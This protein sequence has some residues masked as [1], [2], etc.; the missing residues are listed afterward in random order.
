MQESEQPLRSPQIWNLYS[1]LTS[2]IFQAQL[3]VVQLKQRQQKGSQDTFFNATTISS[4]LAHPQRH[5]K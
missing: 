2:T 5:L 4:F 3:P 1:H